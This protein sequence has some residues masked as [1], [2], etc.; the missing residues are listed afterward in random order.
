MVIICCCYLPHFLSKH[1][2]LQVAY[3]EICEKL[4]KAQS[5]FENSSQHEAVTQLELRQTQENLDETKKKLNASETLVSAL[6]QELTKFYKLPSPCGIG[7][8]MEADM[9]GQVRVGTLEPQMSAQMSGAISEGDIVL[10]INDLKISSK[11]LDTAKATLVGKRASLVAILLKRGNQTFT[12]N[13]KRGSWG[14]EH[15]SVSTEQESSSAWKTSEVRAEDKNS[16]P[17]PSELE[18]PSKEHPTQPQLD[19]SLDASGADNARQVVVQGNYAAARRSQGPG[20]LA[21]SPEV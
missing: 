16:Q 20:P 13:L 17:K 10:S 12:V 18:A 15:A 7:M 8:E 2:C 5:A 9:R 6:K 1:V 19:S 4:Y 21:P 14:P 11:N 3:P